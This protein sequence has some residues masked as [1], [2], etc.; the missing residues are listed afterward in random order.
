MVE[1]DYESHGSSEDKAGDIEK[2]VP[3][4]E[5]IKYRKRA[6]NA[7][8][9]LETLDQQLRESKVQNEKITKQLEDVKSEKVLTSKLSDSGATDLEAAVILAKETMKNNPDDDV[10]TVIRKLR[11]EKSYLFA[12]RGSAAGFNKT[13]GIRDKNSASQSGLERAAKQAAVSGKRN[14]LQEY[15][16]LRRQ[17][18]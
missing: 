14:D 1:T 18:K 7:E 15:L 3:V 11:Q 4:A 8:K 2:M 17:F 13:F 9:M 5:A 12:G 16:R 6:Q 10:D